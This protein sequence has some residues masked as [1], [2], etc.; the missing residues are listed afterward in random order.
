MDREAFTRLVARILNEPPRAEILE[1]LAERMWADATESIAMT[2]TGEMSITFQDLCKYLAVLNT[3]DGET[4]TA[5]M[6]DLYDFNDSGSITM[7]EL[8]DL[9]LAATPGSVVEQDLLMLMRTAEPRDPAS[10]YGAASKARKRVEFFFSDYVESMRDAQ[11]QGMPSLVEKI[12]MRLGLPRT[13]WEDP[14]A[15]PKMRRNSFDR[16]SSFGGGKIGGGS[17][18]SSTGRVSPRFGGGSIASSGRVSPR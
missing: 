11:E 7:T 1:L 15:P 10:Y 4:R 9:I 14:A 17:I 12:C 2:S 18:A 8:S 16:G 6:F 13:R 5:F 3:S